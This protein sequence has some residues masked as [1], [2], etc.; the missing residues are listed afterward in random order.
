MVVGEV[1]AAV[2]AEA[3]LAAAEADLAAVLEVAGVL[4]VA[5][6][7]VAGRTRLESHRVAQIQ[8][9]THCYISLFLIESDFIRNICGRIG[10][11][12]V[13]EQS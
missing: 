2:G 10:F 11:L 1:P 8:I 9:C 4:V 5:E 7:A 13:S 3:D 12:L 6:L